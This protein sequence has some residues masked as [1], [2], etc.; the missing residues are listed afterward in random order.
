VI[1]SFGESRT[2]LPF[3]TRRAEFFE[4]LPELIVPKYDT[5]G[6]GLSGFFSK[7]FTEEFLFSVTL[8]AVL[9]EMFLSELKG[10]E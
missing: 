8:V 7:N 6:I 9:R 5:E 2:D 1:V 3:T 10:S 4:F